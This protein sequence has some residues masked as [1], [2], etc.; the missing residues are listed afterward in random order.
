M[1]MVDHVAPDEDV[2]TLPDRL[3][4]D[5]HPRRGG[6]PGPPVEIEEGAAGRIA[7]LVERKGERI[8]EVLGD[9]RSDPAL[10]DRARRH[11]GGGPDPCGAA[12]VALI[13]CSKRDDAN[14]AERRFA[15]GWVEEH[16]PAFAACALAE[17]TGMSLSPGLGRRSEGGCVPDTAALHDVRSL[18]AVCGDD[19]YAAAEK[20][21]AETR[22]THSQRVVVSY[23]VPTRGDWVDEC[24]AARPGLL[25]ASLSTPRHVELLGDRLRLDYQDCWQGY[26]VTMADGMR[27]AAV[28]VLTAAFAPYPEGMAPAGHAEVLDALGVLPLDEAFAAIVDHIDY[29]PAQ[30]ALLTAMDR[31]PVRAVRVLAPATAGASR[32]AALATEMLKVH[33]RKHPG[34][35]ASGDLPAAARE[36]A[37]A[38]ERVPDAPAGEVPP[39]LAEPPWTR[40]REPVVIKGLKAP[41]ECTM[42]WVPGEQEEWAATDSR[43]CTRPEPHADLQGLAL[44][45]RSGNLAFDRQVGLLAAGPDDLVRPLLEVWAEGKPLTTYG[46]WWRPLVARFGPA[47][48]TIMLKGAQKYPADQEGQVLPFLDAEVAAFMAACL[49]KPKD[50]RPHAL[51]WFDRHGLDAVPPLVPAAVGRAARLRRDAEAA[52][53]LLAGTH[54]AGAVAEAARAAHGDTAAEAV[55]AALEID[56]LELLAAKPPK[57][58]DWADPA[59]L[60]QVLLRGRDRALPA[61]ATRHLMTMLALSKPGEPY[62]GVARVREACDPESLAEFAWSLFERWQWIGAPAADG[63][64]LTALGRLGDDGAVRRLAPLIRAWPGESGHAKAVKGLDVLAEIGTEVALM[65]LHGI[66]QR[67]KFGGLRDQARKKIGEIAE[68]LGLTAA[69]L[70]DRLVPDLGLDSAGTLV[71]DYGPRRFTVGFDERLKPVVSGED[72]EPRLSLPKPGKNDDPELA[73]AAY[74]RFAELKKDVRSIATDQIQ[75]LETAMLDGRCWTPSDFRRFFVEHPLTWHIARRLVWFSEDGDRSAAFRIAEDR[76]FADVDDEPF[77]LPE[78][79]RVLIPHPLLLGEAAEAWA[80]VLADY[81]IL[82]PFPQLGR[83]IEA[84]TEAERE[85]GRLERFEGVTVASG[86]VLGLARRGWVLEADDHGVQTRMVLGLPGRL[87]ME[88]ELDPGIYLGDVAAEPEQLLARVAI[89]AEGIGTGTAEDRRARLSP[90]L[91][92]SLAVAVSEALA[93]LSGLKGAG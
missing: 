27:A 63:W 83:P 69:E 53:R 89:E 85:N 62:P 78:S 33:L 82:Q 23:L 29:Q 77:T 19:E 73:P 57:I 2:L 22:S 44:R 6:T 54:S 80:E 15:H 4:A 21:L 68:G 34:L 55:Q 52:L 11:L 74:K 26:F 10:V 72:G 45:F 31:F 48:K 93:D 76:T 91:P 5:L 64:A 3:L 1:T 7:R 41:A 90:P 17:I 37:A 32:K 18:L 88:A 25:L 50:A 28:P 81:E 66:A 61:E 42:R 43:N 46:D 86:A 12:V 84:L 9:S 39:L 47:M 70:A 58:G 13:V 79:A 38:V 92:V 24:C 16:G 56:P 65:H 40:E 36:I 71:L 49:T 75:R 8:E 60:P 20:L 67:V 14:E 87:Y 59:V 30:A 35:A 51:A